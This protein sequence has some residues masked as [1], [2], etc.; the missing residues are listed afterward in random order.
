MKT[1]LKVLI[2]API[3]WLNAEC[4]YI[5]TLLP[6]L[7]EQGFEIVLMGSAGNPIL[8][9]AKKL[10]FRV[11]DEFNL[12]SLNPFYLGKILGKLKRWLGEEK[13]DLL[14]IH[15]SEGFFLIHRLASRLNPR[16]ALIRVRQDMRPARPDPINR[17]TYQRCDFILVS[18]QLLAQ[19]LIARLHLPR[20]KVKVVYLGIDPKKFVP[21]K[22][23]QELR[24]E[25]GI[26]SS[27]RLVGISARLA[28]VK[29]HKYFLQSA[30][31]IS[32]KMPE[33]RFLVSYRHIEPES[34]FLALLSRSRLKDKFILSDSSDH[35]IDLLALCEVGVLSSVGS[36]ASS[37][38]CLEWMALKKPVVATR[39][40]VLPELIIP[41]ETG[42]LVMPRDAQGMAEAILKLLKHPERARE[43]GEKGYKQLVENFTE[44]QMVEQTIQYFQ[45]AVEKVKAGL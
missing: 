15:R 4:A 41:A 1:G 28:P 32:E 42:Y 2:Y 8:E 22:S 26:P 33:V 35:Y 36:E 44:E 9:E 17:A 43:M 37:R 20:E 29:G 31:I 14:S 16:P 40:G 5:L 19:D 27:A 38:A 34:N 45:Q 39:V 12:L 3:R 18:N 25:L 10:G 13:F 30:R 23:A 24:K 21:R 7:R 11:K 6:R